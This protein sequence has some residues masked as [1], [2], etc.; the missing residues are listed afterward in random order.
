MGMIDDRDYYLGCDWGREILMICF[1]H[2]LELEATDK[3]L[4]SVHRNILR[5][6]TPWPV[7]EIKK[8]HLKVKNVIKIL[9]LNTREEWFLPLVLI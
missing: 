3:F 2:C 7:C 8:N 5:Y 1:S 4:P 6:V 9:Q